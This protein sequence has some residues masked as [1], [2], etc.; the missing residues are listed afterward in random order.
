MRTEPTDQ[1]SA[2]A[3]ESEIWGL[4]GELTQ[5]LYGH[6]VIPVLIALRIV[7]SYYLQL[8]PDPPDALRR[9]MVDL[10]AAIEL[11]P[12]RTH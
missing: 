9:L 12:V 3:L 4:V 11:K 8:M 6:Q 2:M 7:L 1:Q 10:N 5:P